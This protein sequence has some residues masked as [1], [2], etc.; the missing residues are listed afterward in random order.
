MPTIARGQ[1]SIVVVEDGQ[2]GS[3]IVYRGEHSSTALYYNNDIRRDVVKHNSSYY[4]YKG[5]NGASAAWNT[6]NWESFGG[7]YESVATELLLAE[8]A[9]L[10]GFVFSG[11]KLISQK[12]TINGV[13]STNYEDPAFVPYITLDGTNG[14]SKIY[15]GEFYGSVRTLFYA[16]NATNC[17]EIGYGIYK[18]TDKTNLCWTPTPQG[19]GQNLHIV[20]PND[21]S[22][23]GKIVNI[24]NPNYPPF[25]RTSLQFVGDT[26]V[27]TESGDGIFYAPFL[28]EFTDPA[29]QHYVNHS[30]QIEF[31]S[32]MLSFL[33]VPNIGNSI[34]QGEV[35]WICTNYPSDGQAGSSGGSG[36]TTPSQP[37]NAVTTDGTLSSGYLIVGAGGR[38]VEA[39]LFS[40][41]NTFSEQNYS[42]PSGKAIREFLDNYVEE[43]IMDNLPS[44]SENE[45]YNIYNYKDEENYLYTMVENINLRIIENPDQYRMVLLKFRKQHKAGR[46]WAMP[47][48][49]YELFRQG[50]CRR[51][52]QNDISE[53]NSW[54]QIYENPTPWFPTTDGFVTSVLSLGEY[55]DNKGKTQWKNV[56]N[57]RMR[58]GVAIYKYTGLGKIG[59]HRCSNIA[60]VE[61]YKKDA[62]FAYVMNTMP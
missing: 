58:V 41:T 30:S 60:F 59:W 42:L 50:R 21:R 38:S 52:P 29:L 28:G 3:A 26:I 7:Q 57:K 5:T 45:W 56:R 22:F 18:V 40:P 36:G 25:T 19:W 17:Q 61:L 37:S 8:N 55:T 49:H 13:E 62:D 10:A 24:N 6:A 46:K 12:G 15:N 44:S 35:T 39:S 51:L 54:W 53:A 47:M 14:A 20:L 33:C 4:I 2:R 34:G 32:G 23:L 48:F 1:I 16:I 31:L 9:N 27:S 11:G 43:E